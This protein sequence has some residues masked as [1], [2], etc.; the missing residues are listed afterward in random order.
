M[1]LLDTT[2]NAQVNQETEPQRFVFDQADWSLYEHV[3]RTLQNRHVF[4]TFYKGRLEIATVSL[5]HERIAGLIAALIRVLAE[6]TDTSLSGS[7]AVT[8]RRE[9]MDVGVQADTSFYI[10]NEERMRGKKALDLSIDPPPDLAVEVEVTH[11][12]GERKTIY[13]ELGVPEVW[14]YFEGRLIVLVKKGDVYQAVDRSPTFPQISPEEF[15]GF[16]AAGLTQ[17]ETALTKAFRRR[18]REILDALRS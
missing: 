14:R 12:L 10:A 3:S 11:R 15:A 9:E 8:L 2:K 7:G 16:V 13:Q 17:D 1:L 18:V 5:L 6:E 4:I